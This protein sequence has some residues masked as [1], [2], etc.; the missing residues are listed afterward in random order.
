MIGPEWVAQQKKLVASRIRNC[1]ERSASPIDISPC[2][3]PSPAGAA[4]AC[5]SAGGRRTRNET[6]IMMAPTTS[7]TI[8]IEVRQSWPETSQ[9]AS[10]AIVIG[11]MPMPAD[12]SE[13]ARLR[14][15][16]NQPVTVAI[17]GAKIAAQEAPT[18]RPNMNWNASS[19]VAWLAA[20]RLSDSTIDPVSTTGSGP[21]LSVAVPQAMLV[22][23]IARKPIVIALEMPVT[24]QP[25]SLAIGWRNTGSENM[26]PIA[27]QPSKPPA[28]TITQR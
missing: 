23:A 11:A 9:A 4:T 16:S 26:P 15:V 12:T 19:E 10:G 2:A 3:T 18:R 6:G 21:Y 20:N 5:A 17:I 13:T 7:A 22:K 28:A 27:T 24:D 8:C 1:G 25:V 14:W